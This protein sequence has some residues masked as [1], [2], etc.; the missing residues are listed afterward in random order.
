VLGA[1]DG[2]V[3]NFCLVMGVAG[4]SADHG[5]T[6]VAGIAGLL[7]G[8]LSM[9]L[10]EWLSVQ[11]SR[12]LHANQLELQRRTIADEPARAEETLSR[13]YEQKGLDDD[14]ARALAHRIVS[15]DADV[16]LDT[17]AREELGIDPADLGGSAWV[18][19]IV[20]FV[21]FAV[22]ATIP[23]VPYFFASEGSAILASAVASAVALFLLGMAITLLTGRHPVLAGVRQVAFGLAGAA[24]TYGIGT[25]LGTTLA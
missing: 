21:L 18:A 15:G 22:G 19:A 24:V 16:A 23:V 20:S 11:S 17:L 1:N 6:V 25:L 12:E 7:A 2:L 5:A 8:A 4:A 3:S 10:G 14:E 13:V 9:A